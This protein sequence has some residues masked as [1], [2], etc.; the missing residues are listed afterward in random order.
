MSIRSK[1]LTRRAFS[2][3]LAALFALPLVR[4][5]GAKPADDIVE[6]DGWIVKR[7]DLV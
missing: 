1:H 5:F 2:F 4:R 3:A 7:S 6:V